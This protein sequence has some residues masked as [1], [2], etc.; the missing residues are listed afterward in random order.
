MMETEHQAQ[1]LRI[2]DTDCNPAVV[3]SC[4]VPLAPP[5]K[6]M[7]TITEA[8]HKQYTLPTIISIFLAYLLSIITSSCLLN[9]SL[10]YSLLTF[11]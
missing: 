11:W 2:T 7:L 8:A 3:Y 1:H 9:H 6:S 4:T 5:T 10:R